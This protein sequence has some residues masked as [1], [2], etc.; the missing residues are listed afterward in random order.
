MPDYKK[1]RINRFRNT[2]K[3]IRK[4]R[5][6]SEESEDIKMYSG[7]IEEKPPEE[8]SNM[9]VVKGKKLEQRRRFKV[10]ASF[11][12][13]VTIVCIVLQLILPVGIIENLQNITSLIGSGSYPIELDSSA[14]LNS[15]SR[16]SYYY[17]LT[18]T[19]INAFSNAGK[20]VFSHAHGFENPVL[21]TS[22][23]R[24]V[25]FNQG[26]NEYVIYNLKKV[27]K[28]A[29]T[30]SDII[31][32][33]ISDSGTY[34]IVTQSDTYASAVSVYDKNNKLVYE[35]YSSEDIVN[36]I[37]ISP[38]G[39]KIAVS[40]LNAVSGQY[41]SKV[42]V[43]NFNS[44][45]PEFTE[46]FT[47]TFIYSLDSMHNSGFSVVTS[48]NIEFV[49]WSKYQKTD[50]KNEYNLSMFRTGSGGTI[51]VFN[52][53]SDKTDN[54][55]AVFSTSGQLKYEFDFKGI[56][57]DIQI[58]KGHIYCISDTDIYLLGNDGAVLRKAECGFGA[59][60]L[61]VTGTNLVAVITDN[62]IDEIKLEQE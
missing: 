33:N 20:K 45:T 9:R 34:A 10:I 30:K 52:R 48:N 14:T 42:S 50:Y 37:V 24:A 61:T 23:T 32:A 36:N 6:H 53:Q 39:K 12:A 58:A 19:R 5:V 25:V 49:K 55:I 54:K 60:R 31:T 16:S 40:T 56:I 13:I 4:S 43:L 38:N 26:K 21:K 44:A 46:S 18:D 8:K 59:V 22:K 47:E 15:V 2:P 41:T 62:R 27:I 3:K 29:T 7:K 51:A 35:W 57:S 11:V 28:S 17:V 1:K